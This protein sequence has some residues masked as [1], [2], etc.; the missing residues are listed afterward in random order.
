MGTS[1]P[2]SASRAAISGTAAAACS[3]LTVTRTSCEPAAASA[4]ACSAVAAESAVSVFVI[5]CTT[6]GCPDPIC[7]PPTEA[8]TVCL[9]SP[10][11]TRSPIASTAETYLAGLPSCYDPG[12]SVPGTRIQYQGRRGAALVRAGEETKLRAP[13][14][15]EALGRRGRARAGGHPGP[16]DA[17]RAQLHLLVWRASRV[18]PEALEKRLDL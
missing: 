3:L 2:R 4:V 11:T 17:D 16:L 15:G 13:P 14:L 6:T 18:P 12:R 5:D 7:T 8:V 9:R 10:N 1:T